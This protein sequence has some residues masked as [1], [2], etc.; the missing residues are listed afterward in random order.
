V[1]ED[2]GGVAAVVLDV[3]TGV[4]A[5][6]QE[7]ATV[8]NSTTGRITTHINRSLIVVPPKL[9]SFRKSNKLRF[10]SYMEIVQQLLRWGHAH[11]AMLKLKAQP[12]TRR[13]LWQDSTNRNS[14]AATCGSISL[15][16]QFSF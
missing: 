2:A 5:G 8:I 9:Y 13:Q 6:A 15:L 3:A 14:V 4:G 1:R 11:Q 16:A 10:V 7:G 12:E